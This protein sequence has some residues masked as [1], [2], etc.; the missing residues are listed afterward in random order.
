MKLWI[1]AVSGAL[2]PRSSDTVV[3]QQ[4]AA[5]PAANNGNADTQE[6]EDELD[7]MGDNLD[8]L[9]ATLKETQ[10]T[11]KTIRLENQKLQKELDALLNKRGPLSEDE[12][13][14]LDAL[15]SE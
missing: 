1:M 7:A 9:Q 13:A 6:L 3:V 4:Q 2:T 12:E 14:E 8:D 10:Q 5:A 15:L 11:T